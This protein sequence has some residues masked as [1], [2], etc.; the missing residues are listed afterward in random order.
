MN[1]DQLIER[2]LLRGDYGLLCIER[3]PEGP[4]SE[5]ASTVY[6][7]TYMLRTQ[8]FVRL[9][10]FVYRKGTFRLEVVLDLLKCPLSEDSLF[11]Y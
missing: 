9:S 7:E 10:S 11:N 5:V 3:L 6:S 8:A 2:V 4:L 1:W